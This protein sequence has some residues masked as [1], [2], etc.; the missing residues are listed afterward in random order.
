MDM[1]KRGGTKKR[2]TDDSISLSFDLHSVAVAMSLAHGFR[3]NLFQSAVILLEGWLLNCPAAWMIIVL[4]HYREMDWCG[5]GRLSVRLLAINWLLL[6]LQD[7]RAIPAH[8]I[9]Y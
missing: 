3:F 9:W 4:S 1:E 2:E 6:R 5:S 7:C 8:N